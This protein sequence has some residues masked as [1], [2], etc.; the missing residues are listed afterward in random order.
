MTRA[1]LLAIS[2][3][4]EAGVGLGALVV[5]EL[6]V[7]LLVGTPAD[8][9]SRMVT[10]VFGVAL[11]ALAICCWTARA[12][13]VAGAGSGV[14][15]AITFYNAGA[16][17]LLATFA[18]VGSASGLVVWVAAGLHAALGAAFIAAPTQTRLP[19]TAPPR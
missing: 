15:T 8:A 1:G 11:V 7:T 4:L 19:A 9:A 6:A 3:G 16:A 18:A 17:L 2:A 13:T 14:V 10:R 5:P 12:D